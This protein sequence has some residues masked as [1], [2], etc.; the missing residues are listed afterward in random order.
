MAHLEDRA[1]ANAP[2]CARE[3]WQ[4]LTALHQSATKNAVDALVGA[5]VGVD[6]K[7]VSVRM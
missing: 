7:D 1:D 5:G 6:S 3:H 4:G 2:I